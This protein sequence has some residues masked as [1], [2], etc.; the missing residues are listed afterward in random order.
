MNVIRPQ[1][2]EPNTE[3]E[4]VT[5]PAVIADRFSSYLSDESKLRGEVPQSISLPQTVEQLSDVL[6]SHHA[7]NQPTAISARRTGVVG[8]CVPFGRTNLVSLERLNGVLG[9]G[10]DEKTGE[11][12]LSV[13]SGTQ[14][15]TIDEYLAANLPGWYY[16]VDPTCRDAAI[17]GN[18]STNAA[19]MRSFFYGST[20]KWVRGLSVVL[21]DGGVINF[22]RGEVTAEGGRLKI[23]ARNGLREF[24]GRPIR[25]PDTKHSIGY[26]FSDGVDLADIFVAAEGTL[27]A[28]A[29]AEIRLAPRPRKRLYYLQFFN[30]QS[31]AFNFAAKIQSA[32]LS[33]LAVEFLDSRSLAIAATHPG[34][35]AARALQ[36]LRPEFN[37]AVFLDIMLDS[38]A[39]LDRA[40]DLLAAEA[41]AAGADIDQSIAGGEDRDLA[42]IKT[43]RH[44]I[45]EMINKLVAKRK[46]DIPRLHKYSTDM[47]VPITA[48]AEI[49][50]FYERVLGKL[51]LDFFIFGHFGSG[52]LHVNVVPKSEKELDDFLAVY[53]DFGREVIRLGGSVAGEHGIGRVKKEFLKLQYTAQELETLRGIRTFFDPNWLLNPGVLIDRD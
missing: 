44:A 43:L 41:A 22:R 2:P 18:I 3:Y 45:P 10:T 31:A 49:F 16:P 40:H 26:H 34:R 48:R 42:E 20:R 33:I 17:G 35:Q 24:L 52:H 1:Y 27:G 11:P 19:G 32:P 8:G 7:A 23:E 39:D 25:V 50:A 46:L 30:D 47:A 53:L 37:G 13:L 5:D 4:R 36:A 21:S 6:A 28:I 9:S 29:A 51:G 38:D 12:Y 14:L 15:S